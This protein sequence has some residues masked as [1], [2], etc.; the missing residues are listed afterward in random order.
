MWREQ[1]DN[2]PAAIFRPFHHYIFAPFF[3]K[4][5]NQR[6]LE[7]RA[8]MWVFRKHRAICPNRTCLEF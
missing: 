2:G 1:I 4:N 5:L 6:R 3:P 8:K 7:A